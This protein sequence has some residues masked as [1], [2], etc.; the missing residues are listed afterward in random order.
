VRTLNKLIEQAI[1]IGFMLLAFGVAF[2]IA[3]CSVRQ[4]ME[5]PARPDVENLKRIITNKIDEEFSK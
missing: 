3:S 2:Y 4:R 5:C 1:P